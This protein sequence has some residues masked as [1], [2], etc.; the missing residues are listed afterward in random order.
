MEAHQKAML[1]ISIMLAALMQ[2]LDTT[3]ANVALP[4]IQGSLSASQEEINWVLT[5]YITA[6]AIATMPTA[7][8]AGKFGS[9]R[10]FAFAVVGFTISS[11]LCGLSLSIEEI[12][13]FR[14][15]QGVF[16]ACLVPLSQSIL[17]DIN[18]PEKHGSAMALWGI[19]IMIGP[20]LGP[21]LGGVLTDNYSWR[22]VFYINV[23]FGILSFL[24]IWFFGK[25]E[26]PKTIPFDFVGFG[27]FAIFIASLQLLLDRG[28]QL[29]WLDSREVNFYIVICLS[30]FWI[31]CC[32]IL[33][34]KDPFISLEVFKDYNFVISLILMFIVGIILLA[35]IALLPP[36]L[37]N[38]INYPI[39]EVGLIMVP[40]GLGTMVIMALMGKVLHKNIVDPKVFII[41]GLTL[42]CLS[43]WEM[44]LMNL[45]L[46]SWIII[47]TGFIQGMGLGFVFV[48]LSTVAFSTLNPSYRMEATGLFTLI[49]NIG[50]SI[51]IAIIAAF[52]IRE[53]SINHAIISEHI[54]IFN[55]KNLMQHFHI[56]DPKLAASVMELTILR[57]AQMIGYLNSFKLMM[58]ITLVTIPLAFLL[59]K[60]K[61]AANSHV[62][63][64]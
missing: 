34:A 62:V 42:T 33:W 25:E 23:P 56:S 50:S 57:E 53:T 22:W 29:D 7:W 55:F 60:V 44:S 52:L 40:R 48:P 37:Q 16:G 26:K 36:L 58:F 28:N 59:K 12:V 1:T 6:A 49:R 15:L 54:N 4:H 46:T 18:P 3:I 38:L 61:S 14:L 10:T 24:G 32:H 63:M 31:F 47:K 30:S 2:A 51:G 39:T 27:L 17:L 13:L 20:I 5:S 35:T 43:L 8:L 64:E 45:S 41:T 21:S 19:G 11:I 9:R